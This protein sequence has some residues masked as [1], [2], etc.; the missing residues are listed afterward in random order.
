MTNFRHTFVRAYEES[1]RVIVGTAVA[2][3]AR[4]LLFSFGAVPPTVGDT[5]FSFHLSKSATVVEQATVP[6]DV[7]KR[8]HDVEAIPLVGES[9]RTALDDAGVIVP[10]R[11]VRHAGRLKDSPARELR[12]WQP[13]HTR[14]TM[15]AAKL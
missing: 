10:P 11:R 13:A 3:P 7:L 5:K 8:H 14:E 1:E 6:V 15:M 4:A 2:E 12:E 9:D